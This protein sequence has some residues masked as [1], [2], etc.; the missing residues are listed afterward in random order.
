LPVTRPRS[1][2]GFNTGRNVDE[3]SAQAAPGKG[4]TDH[5]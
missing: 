2:P 1:H 3:A 5:G 4:S